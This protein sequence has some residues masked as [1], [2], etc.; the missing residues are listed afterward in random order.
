MQDINIE[1][2]M[3]EI[4]DDIK[5]KGLKDENISFEDVILLGGGTGAP[6]SKE[7]YTD[8]L[9]NAGEDSEVLSYRELSGNPISKIIKKINRRLIAFYIESI[10]DDQNKFNKDVYKGLTMCLSKFEEDNAKMEA[11]E[12][13]LYEA[14]KKISE[15]EKRL[16]G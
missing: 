4:R 8:M 7:A 1:Q 15:L 12:K 3:Q 11:L 16:N 10:V 13:K 6:Y 14:E 9:V 5:A 2:I